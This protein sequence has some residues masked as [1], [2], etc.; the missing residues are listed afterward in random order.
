M[1]N[2]SDKSLLMILKN[3]NEYDG[4]SLQIKLP[5][6]YYLKDCPGNK[7]TISEIW[8]GIGLLLCCFTF[9]LL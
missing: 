2:Q 6:D 5:E 4:S 3:I 9:V 8:Y 7:E 1:D